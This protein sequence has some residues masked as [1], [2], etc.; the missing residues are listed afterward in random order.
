MSRLR[1][2]YEGWAVSKMI[3]DR[4]R[5]GLCTWPYSKVQAPAQGHGA[6]CGLSPGPRFGLMFGS[7]SAHNPAFN[8]LCPQ[9]GHIT[10]WSLIV[11][12]VPLHP[13]PIVVVTSTTGFPSHSDRIP[14]HNSTRRQT[15]SICLH[16]GSRP[17]ICRANRPIRQRV[18]RSA[19]PRAIP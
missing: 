17:Q 11:S 10:S 1:N 9:C 13:R 6:S 19:Y 7:P 4:Y 14:P 8:N 3:D 16:N 18:R 5:P 2:A 15:G 12:Q